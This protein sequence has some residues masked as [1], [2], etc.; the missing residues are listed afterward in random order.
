MRSAEHARPLLHLAN[1][2]AALTRPSSHFD[3]VRCGIAVYGCSPAPEV[4]DSAGFG[5]RPA[6]TASARLA[7]PITVKFDE[8]R[9][10]ADDG[11]DPKVESANFGPV[12]KGG[13][14]KLANI[15]DYMT[16]AAFTLLNH[17]ADNRERWLKRFYEI[18]KEAVKGEAQEDVLR[19]AAEDLVRD[20][21]G[22]DAE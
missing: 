20:A 15:T 4:A 8:L 16:T 13:E 21:M 18:G 14:W 11:H 2:A 9:V 19:E 6:M 10:P 22:E 7:T 1:S 12:W 3:L 17:A 5:L